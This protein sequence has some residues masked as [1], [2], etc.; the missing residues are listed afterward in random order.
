[1]LT[2]VRLYVE[3][4]A[5]ERSGNQA[6]RQ[7]LSVSLLIAVISFGLVVTHHLTSLTGI[8]L[9]LAGALFIRPISGFADRKGGWRRLFVR[10]MPVLTL[11]TCLGLWVV[12]VAPTTVGYLFPHVSGPA[13]QLVALITGSH[14]SGAARTIFSHS[15]SPGYEQAAAIAAPVIVAVALLF[16][17]I[18]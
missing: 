17:G 9:L 7:A 18:P 3:S 12:F 15:T 14:A 5:A 1:M 4:L 13:G 10:W 6:W 8:A 11:A 16:A 2:I